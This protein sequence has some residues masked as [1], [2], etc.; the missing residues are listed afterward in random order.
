V[1]N[2]KKAAEL[3]E[4]Y[5]IILGLETHEVI[6]HCSD[7]IEIIDRVNSDYL[8]V[9]LDTGNSMSNSDGDPTL[10]ILKAIEILA[11]NIVATHIRDVTYDRLTKTWRC[12]PCGEGIVDFP[13]IAMILKNSKY[14]GTLA[15]EYITDNQLDRAKKDIPTGIIKNCIEYLR[16]L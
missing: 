14:K 3:A 10:S 12:V 9:T 5:D 4:S 1:R 16:Q 7:V 15:L 11:P 8:G 6:T 13:A 2:L